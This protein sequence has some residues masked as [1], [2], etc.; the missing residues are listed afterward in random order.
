MRKAPLSRNRLKKMKRH[1]VSAL[2]VA[3]VAQNLLVSTA[4]I[5]ETPETNAKVESSTENAENAEGENTQNVEKTEEGKETPIAEAAKEADTEK[6]AVVIKEKATASNPAPVETENKDTKPGTNAAVTEDIFDSMPEIGTDEFTTWFFAHK[7]NADLWNWVMKFVE[8]DD[9]NPDE[10]AAAFLSWFSEHE[11]AVLKAYEETDPYGVALLS[12]S[13]GDLWTN[14][15]GNTTWSGDGTE[16]AP[17]EISSLA[18]LMGLSEMVAAGNSFDGKYFRLTQSIDLGNININNGNWNPI[19]WY[20]NKSDLSSAVKNKFKGN[21]DGEG[22]TISGLKVNESSNHLSNIGLFGAVEGGSIKNLNIEAGDGINGTDAVGVLAG[23]V[24]GDTYIYNVTV[25]G[26]TLSGSGDVGGLVGKIVGKS[27]SYKG[28]VTIENCKADGVRIQST[29]KNAYAGG[30]AGNAQNV[31]FVDVEVHTYD[32]NAD[33]IQGQGYVGGVAGRLN[34]GS[35][36]NSY[37]DGTI[38]GNGSVAIGGIVGEY[39]GGNI[40]L[41]RFNGEIARS[42]NGTLAHE[43]TFIG[44]RPNST[45]LSYGIGK[46][47][48]ISYLFAKDAS[49]DKKVCGSNIDSDNAFTT[50]AHIGYFTNN[51]RNYHLVAGSV[52]KEITDKYFYEELED[53]VKNIVTVKV[54]NEFAS[55]KYA[56]GCDFSIDHFAPNGQ[57][58]PIRGYLVS[59]PRIDTMNA[60]GTYD[61]DVA[62]LT[63]I[64]QTTNSYYRTID[65]DNPSAVAA[66]DTITVATA[67]K[68]KDG[69]RYQMVADE[70]EAGK[71]KPPTYTDEDGDP[72]KMAYVNGGAYTFDMPECDTELNVEYIKVTTALAMTP[73]ETTLKVK[74]TRSGDRK[75]PQIVTEVLDENNR[76]IAKYI[77]D[78]V[79]VSPTPITI[80]AEHNGEGSANDK[81]VKWSVDNNDL[82]TLTNV[83][84]TTYTDKDAYIMPNL[85]SNFIQSTLNRLVQAQVDSGYAEAI[86]NTVYS[87]VAVVTATTNPNT[88]VNNIPVVGNTRVNVE[89]QIDDQTTRR[90]EGLSLNYSDV[91]YTVTRTLTGDRT[92]PTETYTCTQP[93]VLAAT[94]N[95]VQPFWKNVSWK[96]EGSGSIITLTPNGTNNENCSIGI[97]YDENGTANPAWI[98]NVINA[99]NQKHADDPYALRNGKATNTEVVTATSEDQ[100][101]GVVN[102][103]CNVTINFVTVDQTVV[104]P[105]SV[106]M[107]KESV[108]YNL[109]ITKKGDINSENASYD[110]FTATDLDCT[111]LPDLANDDDHKPYDRSV[112]WSVS[113]PDVL[114]ID[115]TGKITPNP[116]AEWIKTAQKVAPY[117]A[118][119]TVSVHATTKDGGKVGET[120]VTLNYT[121]KCVN[122]DKDTYT[123]NLTLKKTGRTSS[124]TLTWEGQDAVKLNAST[125]PDKQ[126]ISFAT[127][128]KDI[129]TVAEDGTIAPVL[130][131]TKTW[132]QPAMKNPY[133]ATATVNVSVTDGKSTDV[134][135]VTVNL[136]VIDN[137]Y[138]GSSSSSGGGGGGGGSSHSYTK[139]VTSVVSGAPA[140]S[141]TGTWTKAENG[142]WLFASVSKQYINEWAYIYNPYA[143]N[144]QPNVSWFRF[145]GKGYMVT[146]WFNDNG[147]W[148]YLNPSSDGTQGRM[149]TGWVLINHKYYYLSQ[150][151][152]TKQP[153]G[154][155]LTSTT[156]PDGYTVNANGEWTVNG[157]VQ[158]R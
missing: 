44:T 85:S 95:P 5:A 54:G 107:S 115:Q 35:I 64:G 68:N 99:D 16:S 1:L 145:D 129:I 49:A 8:A 52:D 62:T 12:N 125:Y 122:L 158:Y 121:T 130:D 148:Y 117:S 18:D 39:D 123:Y 56:D 30:I 10:E 4:A 11:E 21:F 153:V 65:K 25:D 33:R 81:T 100:T 157:V 63:A 143:A 37:V 15:N 47:N 74:Q 90:V 156:T 147:T 23:S 17:Y 13:T 126:N 141:V 26:A 151:S 149:L 106:K 7:D 48:T 2:A 50:D 41:A 89:F 34:K 152:S 73:T 78:Q 102:A 87:D 79:A 154:S 69:N 29:G 72:V 132:M 150:T 93:T 118:T 110:G 116:N 86:D 58:A 111:V 140:G 91:V 101:H 28:T 109:S 84:T 114:T 144:G 40:I 71:V 119:K 55:G 51:E 137:T 139:K 9:E 128:N 131:A 142:K 19:G 88:S 138:S 146:G 80:H 133:T 75:N 96:D 105:E 24:E 22:N 61:T 112:T 124:P 38:G 76:Q 3:M 31:N 66:G 77:G 67:P 42:N 155:L 134:C 94:L 104:H 53:A 103:K 70:N 14:W 83:D 6:K 113:D 43:G 20:Q 32:G 27:S 59:I 82:L 98:Q 36:Y 108:N 120:K 46:N 127:S 57:G 135:V 92:N 45:S 136:K 97:R 60:N